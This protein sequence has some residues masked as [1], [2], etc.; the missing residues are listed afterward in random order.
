MLTIVKL[1]APTYALDLKRTMLPII[2]HNDDLSLLIRIANHNDEKKGGHSEWLSD[3][4]PPLDRLRTQIAETERDLMKDVPKLNYLPENT[5]E[6]TAEDSAL[7]F[8]YAARETFLQA[9]SEFQD[10]T[11]PEDVSYNVIKLPFTE[12]SPVSGQSSSGFGYRLH[13][14]E[15]TVRFHYGTDFAA[16]EGTDVHAFADGVVLEA[17]QSEGYGNYVKLDHGDGFVTLY[18]HCSELLVSEG[19]HVQRGD[20]I[21]RVGSTGMSTGPHLHFELIQNGVYLNPEFYLY[22]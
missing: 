13:P 15:D 5:V 20:L 18:G 19:D 10:L 17:S 7:S 21:A 1:I 16:D 6:D 4:K 14:I 2:D 11:I 22:A 8:G 3:R 12:T 9:Q